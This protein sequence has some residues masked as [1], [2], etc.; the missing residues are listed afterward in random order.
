MDVLALLL[1]PQVEEDRAFEAVPAAKR[2]D[3][4]GI[5]R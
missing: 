2:L 3:H 5:R 4:A 1:P